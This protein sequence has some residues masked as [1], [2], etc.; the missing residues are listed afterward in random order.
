ME[1]LP[2]RRDP[3]PIAIDVERCRA[4]VKR[5]LPPDWI[6]WTAATGE[7]QA[8]LDEARAKYAGNSGATTSVAA[9]AIVSLAVAWT[10]LKN[11]RDVVGPGTDPLKATLAPLIDWWIAERGIP[12]AIDVLA[13][14]CGLVQTMSFRIEPSTPS[15]SGNPK[16]SREP[17]RWRR[18]REH[19]ARADD[20]TYAAARAHAERIRATNRWG[21][22]EVTSFAFPWEVEW[23]RA[24]AE[25][26]GV[27]PLSLIG[28]MLDARTCARIIERHANDAAMIL[29]DGRFVT[30]VEIL[31][32]DALAPIRAAMTLEWA[33]LSL[34]TAMLA[35]FATHDVA[36]TM[37]DALDRPEAETARDFFRKNP[38]L[39]LDA[40]LEP[41]ATSA[42]H[43]R[44]TKPLLA[45]AVARAHE[46]AVALAHETKNVRAKNMLVEYGASE[47]WLGKKKPKR[48]LDA[49]AKCPAV[50]AWVK[51]GAPWSGRDA[52]RDV[53]EPTALVE[54][55]RVAANE[56]LPIAMAA[57]D[58]L[59][60]LPEALKWLGR[61]EH[62]PIR[63]EVDE[64]ARCR[65]RE[66]QAVRGFVDDDVDDLAAP[67]FAN[68]LDYGKRRFFAK[69]DAEMKPT[70]F[71]ADGKRVAALPRASKHDD[72]DRAAK[73]AD[74]WTL[75][76]DD[77]A[78]EASAQAA[79]MEQA[80]LAGREF[81]D[82]IFRGVVVKNPVL[83]TLARRLVWRDARGVLFRVAE[84]G[85]FASADDAVVDVQS[86][87]RIADPSAMTADERFRWSEVMASYEILQP[88]A[89]LGR[90]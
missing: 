4:E 85:T 32:E 9:D 3:K 66:L 24:D 27:D 20:A 53:K 67:S 28:T 33:D 40:L 10:N 68:V 26:R 77:A 69:L 59:A 7:L 52:L 55:I 38:L 56:A 57:V 58:A 19:V 71:D 82:E 30:M 1:V 50:A 89:Q 39:A 78:G 36:V 13:Y 51:E 76:R 35:R 29:V 18:L 31:G 12:H 21:V 5:S 81:P 65:A 11:W 74:A 83:G 8:A 22:R 42:A 54:I 16:A 15:A 73:A 34:P 80:M 17:A 63:P 23:A 86:P 79:R 75:F 84:D 41:T 48:L 43:A 44:R 90:T 72:A 88:F 87:V 14:A 25:A 60:E 61:I 45:S 62:T 2:F 37:L 46:A 49:V 6:K 64:H 47:A 70:I